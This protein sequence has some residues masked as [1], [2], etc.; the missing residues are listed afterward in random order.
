MNYIFP[1][2]YI[3]RVGPLYTAQFLIFHRGACFQVEEST[4]NTLM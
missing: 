4:G 2:I 3:T 1:V